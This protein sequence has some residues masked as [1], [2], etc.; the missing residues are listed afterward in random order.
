MM[1]KIL[2]GIFL[3]FAILTCYSLDKELMEFEKQSFE[4]ENVYPN[5]L[6]DAEVNST[7]EL[8]N[9]YEEIF[10]HLVNFMEELDVLS[11]NK[12]EEDLIGS[13]YLIN[14]KGNKQEIYD[15]WGSGPEFHILK[16][17]GNLYFLRQADNSYLYYKNNS[18]YIFPM[19]AYGIIKQIKIFDDELYFFVLSGDKWILD[20][21]HNGGVYFYRKGEQSDIV[22]P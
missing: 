17:K 3:I 7:D 8:R 19:F 10:P 15:N 12:Q 20:P 21:I 16:I 11:A 9:Y 13:W 2:Y 14:E 22:I 18:I 4:P 1:K 6:Y 5:K